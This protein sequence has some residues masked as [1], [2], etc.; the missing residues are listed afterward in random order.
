MARITTTPDASEQ[1]QIAREEVYDFFEDRAARI[2]A[3]GPIRAVIYQDS[4]PDLAE[5]RDRA[6]KERLLPKLLLDGSQRLLDIGCGTGRWASDLTPLCRHYHGIDFSPGLV[7][8]A[9][10]QFADVAHARFS[11]ASA[12]RFSLAG[13]GETLP[14]D[15]MLCCGILIYLND[16]EVANAFRCMAASAAPKTRILL[17]EPMAIGARLTLQGHHSHEL[18]HNYNAIYRTRDELGSLFADSLAPLGFVIREEGDLFG[19]LSLN[20][21]TDTKQRWMVLE[22]A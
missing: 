7:A 13:M 20:N 1:P 5:R 8:H 21:R 15:R 19:D 4:H 12:D 2:D 3:L 16:N 11:I 18:Q 22:R 6:E 10:K 17:R 9:S 14:F